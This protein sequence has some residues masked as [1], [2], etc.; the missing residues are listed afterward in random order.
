[1][2]DA[3]QMTAAF[4]AGLFTIARAQQARSDLRRFR[5]CPHCENALLSLQRDYENSVTVAREA[6]NQLVCPDGTEHMREEIA[7]AFEAEFS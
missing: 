6:I 5:H 1:M 4:Q 7:T 3:D 2:S